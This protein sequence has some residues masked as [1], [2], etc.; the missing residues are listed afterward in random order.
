MNFLEAYWNKLVFIN[1]EI[2]PEI[3]SPYVP[4]GTELDF[5]EGKCYVSLVGFL[6]KETRLLG[7]KIPFHQEFEEVNLRFYVKRYTNSGWHRGVVFIQEIVPKKTLALVANTIYKEHYVVHEMAHSIKE[8]EQDIA[9]SYYWKVNNQVQKIHIQSGNT[10]QPIPLHTEA[11]FIT[12]HYYGY[13]KV[14]GSTFEY[15]VVHPSWE[16]YPIDEIRLDVDFTINYGDAFSF[17]NQ[18]KPSSVQMVEGSTVQ[19]K[20]K[21]KIA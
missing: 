1:Y 9:V 2:D 19:V 20:T 15:E 5:W 16:E 11:A 12:E 17:L 21:T 6:F 3:L 8:R 18:Q 10:L 13:T 7:V 4:E 14:E